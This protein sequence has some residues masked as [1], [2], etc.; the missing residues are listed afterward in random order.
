MLKRLK[1]GTKMLLL[2]GTILSLLLVTLVW[3][4]YGLSGTVQNGQQVADGNKLRGE[5]LQREVDH[6]NWA[7]KVSTFLS[8][9]SIHELQVQL[10]HTQ[11]GF[12][13]WYYGDGRREAEVLLPTLKQQLQA[14][15]APHQQLHASAQKIA[16]LYRAA[17][18]DLPQFLTEKELDHMNWVYKVQSAILS[19]KSGV[20]VQLDHTKCGFGTFLYGEAGRKAAAASPEMAALLKQLEQPHAELHAEGRRLDQMLAES[21]QNGATRFFSASVIPTLKELRGL[22]K[23]AQQL[24]TDALQGQQ[25]AQQVFVTETQQHL[26]EVQGLLR[27]MSKMSAASIMSDEEMIATAI[28]T[29]SGVIV[30]G[31]FALLLGSLLAFFIARSITGPLRRAFEVMAEYGRGDTRDQNL[32]MGQAVNCSEAN[33]C[34]QRDCSSYGQIGYCWVKT[35]SFGPNPVCL[36]LTNGSYQDCRECKVYSARDEVSELGSVLVGMAQS[37]QGRCEL[38]RAIAAGDL[39]REV[40]I[41]SPSDQLGLALREMLAGLR[42]MVSSIQLA[43]EQIASG[44]GQVA[45]ASQSLSQGATES[46]SSLEQVTASMNQMAAQVRQ[47]AEHANQANR[48]SLDSQKAAE[49]GNQQMQEM[50]SAMGRINAA[51]QN[52]SKIIKVI[53]EIAFQTNLLALNAAVE[54]ARAGQHGKG[55]AV[56]A[57]EVRN[58]AARSA[59]AASET[60]ELIQGSVELTDQGAEIADRTALALN[61]ILLSTNQVAELLEEIAKAANEQAQGIGQVSEGLGQ[62][63]QV[64]QQNTASAEESAA[65]SEELSGQAAQMRQMLQRFQ[66]AEADQAAAPPAELA[67]GL[68][69]VAWPS[70]APQA[71]AVAKAQISLNDREFGKF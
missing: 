38:A 16:S 13:Q 46:A 8:D 10:D 40:A 60:A 64:T 59:K 34:G 31:V 45:D 68:N 7:K 26:K 24:A 58:L 37:L 2:S 54:A 39:T 70:P 53:D 44:A 36:K 65:A 1:I 57:E 4:I 28:Q 56:V 67:A 43:G 69:Q 20:G 25:Q 50:V 71:P 15:G 30:T 27:E 5:L 11:C 33:N 23:Q 32:P 52:I 62:I 3:G 21:D 12:G 17:D 22:L 19:G 55:F 14:I 49:T 35:G 51:G 18:P 42:E 48:L 63:D 41:S 66:L 9:S 29:R 47:S 6:L 61:D